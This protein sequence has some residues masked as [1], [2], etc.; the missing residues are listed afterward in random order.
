M[1]KEIAIFSLSISFILGIPFQWVRYK[2]E[3]GVYIFIGF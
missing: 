1:K 3:E 2:G